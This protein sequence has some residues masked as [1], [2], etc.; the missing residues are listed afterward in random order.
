MKYLVINGPNLNMLGIREPEIYG[1]TTYGDLC[2]Y[3]K[4]EADEMGDE[5]EIVQSNSE[6]KLI[7]YIHE[8]Y[9]NGCEGIVIN[10]GA[11]THYSYAILDALKAVSGKVP[12]VEVHLS[13]I[14]ARDEFRHNSVIRPACVDMVCGMGVLGYIEA[15]KRLK[16]YLDKK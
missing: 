1:K 11:Y 16:D 4:S 7:D 6:G 12:T 3:I 10:A 9:F 14:N 2:A 8:T 5:V 13:D 15:A